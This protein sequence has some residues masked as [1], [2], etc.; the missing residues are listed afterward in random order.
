MPASSTAR[1][2]NTAINRKLKRV[3]ARFFV[4]ILAHRPH[5]DRQRRIQRPHRLSKR[6]RERRDVAA[7]A[8]DDR[9][10]RRRPALVGIVDLPTHGTPH[11]EHAHVLDD[12]D[13]FGKRLGLAG[14]PRLQ[15]L[16]DRRLSRPRTRGKQL[17]DDDDARTIGCV[18]LVEKASG[19]QA[20]A[21]RAEVARRHG[22]AVGRGAL[23]VRGRLLVVGIR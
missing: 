21:H 15:P 17:V 13:D 1:A 10:L 11:I 23:P 22:A 2:A 4:S 20:R 7:R 8:H 19:E 16:A 5:R 3:C 12:T 6:R 14:R 9:E 18:A